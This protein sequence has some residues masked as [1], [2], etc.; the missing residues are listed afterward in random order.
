MTNSVKNRVT[1]DE[2]T[3]RQFKLV[4]AVLQETLSNL[5]ADKDAINKVLR[6]QKAFQNF[7]KASEADQP[8]FSEEIDKILDDSISKMESK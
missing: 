4:E 6:L 5:G 3:Q 1:T 2:L 7:D 8:Q